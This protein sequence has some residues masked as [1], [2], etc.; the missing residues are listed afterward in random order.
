MPENCRKLQ[1]FAEN[2]RFSQIHPLF[3]VIP[4][5]GAQETAE[6][7]RVSEKIEDFVQK[8]A[9]ISKLQIGVRQRE[10]LLGRH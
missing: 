5:F 8:A 3:L 10:G 1:I 4:E 6:K 9:G 2:R 7:R